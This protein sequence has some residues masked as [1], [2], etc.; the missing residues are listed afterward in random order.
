MRMKSRVQDKIQAI[1][2]RMQGYSYS[3]IK[4]RLGVSKSLLSGWL[5]YVNL[6]KEQE[7]ILYQNLTNRSKKGVAKAVEVNTEKRKQRE[8]KAREKSDVLYHKHKEDRFFVAGL[9]LYWAEGSKRS[10][11]ASFVNSDPKMIKFMLFW[12]TKYLDVKKEDIFL[13]LATHK[14]FEGENYESFWSNLTKIPLSQFKK[15]SYKPN[16]H[17]VFKKNPD[18]KGCIRIEIPGGMEILRIMIYLYE[19]FI[20]ESKVLYSDM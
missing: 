2:L 14:D 13:R 7:Q 8:F 5:K 15:T 11:S 18:Y 6:N 20:F 12:V 16:K 3:Q 4:E 1:A 9:C 10:S 19:S 17:G